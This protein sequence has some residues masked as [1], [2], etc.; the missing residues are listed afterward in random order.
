MIIIEYIVQMAEMKF[1]KYINQC[2]KTILCKGET[3][4]TLTIKSNK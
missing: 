1:G 3:R 4:N 2:N